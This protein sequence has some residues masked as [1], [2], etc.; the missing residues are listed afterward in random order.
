MNHM[1]R[2]LALAAAISLAA[3]S[4]GQSGSSLPATSA[5]TPS[6]AQSPTSIF[7]SYVLPSNVRASCAG[8]PK[9]GQAHCLAL[10]RTDVGDAIPGHVTPDEAVP[11]YGPADLHLAYNI[12]KTG[13]TGQTVGIVDAYDDPNAESDLSAYRSHFKL[14]PCTTGNGCLQKLNQL[15]VAGNYPTPDS[16]WAVEISLDLDMVSAM[17]PAC[18]IVL[19][20]AD[21]NSFTD[22]G[23]SVDM[24]VTKGADIVS[25]SYSGSEF[26]T[27]NKDYSHPGHVIVAAADDDGI[28]P[29]QPCSYQT[30]VC[31]GGTSLAK[32][33]GTRGW[34]E[35]AWRYTGSGCSE[36]VAKPTWQHDKGCRNRTETDVS[37]I[38]DPETGVAIYDSYEMCCWYV[39][40][41]TSVATPLIASVYALAGN[42]ASQH[43]AENIWDGKGDHLFDITSGRN[44]PCQQ[45]YLCHARPGYDGPTGWGTPNGLGAF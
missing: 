25:N 11:G 29:Q 17:C 32:G 23:A 20:E 42:A 21:S 13:G 31:V 6:I 43:A 15:G 16:G 14:H 19:V 45:R 37:A 22:L 24:A 41:G 38:A 7:P 35:T 9:I 44:G 12:P 28:G 34:T 33:G 26:A 40:G 27:H 39:Y 10:M 8:A 18:K 4:G 5:I 1:P 30:I 2:G 3:C 36:A